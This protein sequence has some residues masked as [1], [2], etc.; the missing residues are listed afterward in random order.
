[1]DDV[2][3]RMFLCREIFYIKRQRHFKVVK[4]TVFYGVQKKNVN[5]CLA[6]SLSGHLTFHFNGELIYTHSSIE[7]C[8]QQ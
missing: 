7:V 8:N 5:D 4:L 2:E 6:E 3:N 1:M